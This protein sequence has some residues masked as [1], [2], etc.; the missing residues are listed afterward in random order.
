M[1]RQTRIYGTNVVVDNEVFFLSFWVKTFRQ[2]WC[3]FLIVLSVDE[4]KMDA[5]FFWV[6]RQLF[7]GTSGK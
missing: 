3:P 7:H 5:T 2:S 4:L 1:Q 6:M